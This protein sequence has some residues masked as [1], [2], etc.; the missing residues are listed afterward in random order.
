VPASEEHHALH[1][2]RKV[3]Q[4]S[5]KDAFEELD[6]VAELLVNSDLKG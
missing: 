5:C 1:C 2:E 6:A 3:E 4:Q